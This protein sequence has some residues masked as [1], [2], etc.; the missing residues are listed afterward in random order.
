MDQE[1]KDCWRFSIS[2]RSRLKII[3]NRSVT[4]EEAINI[5]LDDMDD[6][7]IIDEDIEGIEEIR[8]VR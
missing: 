7:D 5:F 4:K 8:E 3:F 1:K 2:Q 6:Y